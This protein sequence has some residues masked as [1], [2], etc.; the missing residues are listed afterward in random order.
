[1]VPGTFAAMHRRSF[2]GTASVLALGMPAAAEQPAPALISRSMDPLNLEFPFA[3]LDGFLTPNK[4]FYVRNHFAVPKVDVKSWR[5][6]VEGAVAKPLELTYQDLLAM[7]TVTKPMTLECAGNGRMLLDVKVPG[8]QWGLGAV[9]TAEWTG[10]PLATLLERAGAVKNGIDVILEGSDGGV[11][12]NEPKPQGALHFA[13]ALPMAKAM[14]DSVLLALKMGGADLSAEHG[15]PLRAVV[16]GWYGMASIKWL[17][18]IVVTERPF[19]GYEQTINY[20]IWERRDGVPQLVPITTAQVK[21]SIARPTRDEKIAAGK[22]YR[23]HGAAWAGEADV[24]KVEISTDSGKTWQPARLLGR[25]VPLA[26][27]LWEFTWTAPAAGRH[28]LLARATDSRGNVQ[29]LGRDANRRSYM[30]NHVLP[31]PVEVA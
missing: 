25:S 7:P 18:R 11:L 31:T 2:L 28:T 5:L 30:I 4:L 29:P 1:M 19:L 12:K 16:G 22:N 14:S 8:V 9:S 24:A 17:S 15:F 21:A 27:R 6:R 13:R 23:I 10:V 20:G 26:W 3:T